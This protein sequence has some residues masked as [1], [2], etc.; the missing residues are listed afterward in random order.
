MRYHPGVSDV[1][2]RL[3]LVINDDT[4]AVPPGGA[5]EIIDIDEDGYAH[6]TRPSRSG[7]VKNILFNGSVAIPAKA[8]NDDVGNT[9]A[10][11][12]EF[13]TVAAYLSNDG[14]DPR[15]GEVWGTQAGSWQLRRCQ[16][17]GF[18][19]LGGAGEGMVNIE[20]ALSR[21]FK[22]R[23]T[24][25]S[26]DTCGQSGSGTST[27]HTVYRYT[28]H[29]VH[30]VLDGN[31]CEAWALDDVNIAT[32]EEEVTEQN[33]NLVALGTIVD[34][35]YVTSTDESQSGTG[36]TGP[37]SCRAVF[38]HEAEER[39]ITT[40]YIDRT[41][42]VCNGTNYVLAR[43]RDRFGLDEDGCL[44]VTTQLIS[45]AT[46]T[47]CCADCG[48]SS[49]SGGG[50]CKT[51]GTFTAEQ[52]CLTFPTMTDTVYSYPA[53]AMVGSGF[54]I[55]LRNKV[56][57]LDALGCP[58]SVWWHGEE[59]LPNFT[60]GDEIL[61]SVTVVADLVVFINPS[62]ASP[63]SCAWYLYALVRWRRPNGLV[64]SRFLLWS[65][66]STPTGC[67]VNDGVLIS[68]SCTS[69]TSAS[70]STPGAPGTCAIFRSPESTWT[71]A[72]GI[73][74]DESGSG[75]AG[76][77]PCTWECISNGWNLISGGAGC[78]NPP[79]GTFICATNGAIAYTQE[80]GDECDPDAGPSCA[81]CPETT[82]TFGASGGGWFPNFSNL[83]V[84]PENGIYT[85]DPVAIF[86][87]T[88]TISARILFWCEGNTWYCSIEGTGIAFQA[89]AGATCAS[90][91]FDMSFGTNNTLCPGQPASGTITVTG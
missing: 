54:K 55:T 65:I 76:D 66:P 37:A 34:V 31:A 88:G 47:E 49:G 72:V 14:T 91:Q 33:N 87:S 42:R 6:I 12:R 32:I 69:L 50:C 5:M 10:G 63:C 2:I 85:S 64:E 11:T 68:S 57:R 46:T 89:N 28:V 45:Q 26:E 73:C 44:A 40:S 83:S 18:L 75:A 82:K 67:V 27:E 60:Y 30:A 17:P 39:C 51:C 52:Y 41:E 19:I 13:P 90:M 84:V 23:I 35:E 4:E 24:A 62:Y 16:N 48:Q 71:L 78:T 80:N 9:G 58:E 53:A 86:C 43:Y 15:I 81:D 74:S 21:D 56:C 77:C 8:S 29:S 61:S 20:E 38:S 25:V 79:G 59:S 1:P 3:M 70:G 7:L 36:L 22:G